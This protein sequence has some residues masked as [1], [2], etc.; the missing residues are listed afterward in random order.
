M[1]WFLLVPLV[2][3][4]RVLVMC[5]GNHW[6]LCFTASLDVVLSTVY[7]VSAPML[8]SHK[9]FFAFHKVCTLCT[10]L[11]HHKFFLVKHLMEKL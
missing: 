11:F 7:H 6:F 1:L 9:S 8:R 2:V 10:K 4:F 5:F 3:N